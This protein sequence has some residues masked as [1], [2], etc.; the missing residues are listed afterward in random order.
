MSSTTIAFTSCVDADEDHEQFVWKH[1]QRHKPNVLL[2][3]GD[4]I[5][6]DFSFAVLGAKKPRGKHNQQSIYEFAAKMHRLYRNQWAVENFRQLVTSGI[7]VGLIWDDHDFAWNNS[8]GSGSHAVPAEFRLVSRTLFMQF[9]ARLQ[10]GDASADYPPPPE[11]ESLIAGA[12]QDQNTL[13]QGIQ[14]VIDHGDSR[15]VLLDGRSFREDPTTFGR[16]LMGQRPSQWLHG[17]QQLEWMRQQFEDWSGHKIIAA[18]STLNFAGETWSD[19]RDL[20]WMQDHAPQ[21]SIVLTGDIH[22]NNGPQS[23]GQPTRFFEVTSSGAA[24]PGVIKSLNITGGDTG[25]YGILRLSEQANVELYKYAQMEK[26][27]LLY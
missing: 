27:R 19:Y 3:L 18:G 26:K 2:I 15:I 8:R 12:D 13:Q 7:E 1:I 23:F 17:E 4:M 14:T 21:N 6:M 22:R 5:Y 9:K 16:R 25:N 11:I 20:Q 24:R 10:A